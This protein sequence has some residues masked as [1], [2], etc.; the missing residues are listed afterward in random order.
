MSNIKMNKNSQGSV[1]EV[2]LASCGDGSDWAALLVVGAE[3]VEHLAW[4]DLGQII[5]LH[6]QQ[7]IIVESSG[8]LYGD[9]GHVN[10]QEASLSGNF[11]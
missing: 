1:L 9:H 8:L 6:V 11:S 4:V 3:C 10:G 5:I 7:N 2:Q